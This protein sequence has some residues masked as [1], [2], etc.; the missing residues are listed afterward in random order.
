MPETTSSAFFKSFWVVIIDSTYIQ[1]KN[2]CEDLPITKDM[3]SNNILGDLLKDHLLGL[4]TIVGQMQVKTLFI[5]WII[6]DFILLRELL[7]Q[8]GF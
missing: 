3:H 8:F 1:D 2:Q 5:I 7:D 4:W 6:Y